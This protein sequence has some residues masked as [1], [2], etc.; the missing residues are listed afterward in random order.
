[1]PEGRVA[2]RRGELGR[3]RLA[4]LEHVLAVADRDG[5]HRGPLAVE[6]EHLLGRLRAQADG[7]DVPD[8]QHAAGRSRDHGPRDRLDALVRTGGLERE[9]PRA[10]VD[11]AARDARVA[12][13]QRL[14][15]LPDRHA[16]SRE[17]PEV[18][19]DARLAVRDAVIVDLLH[20]VHPL[21]LT[22]HL[23]GDAST[24]GHAASGAISAICRNIDVGRVDLLDLERPDLGRQV[25]PRRLDLAHELVV[26]LVG[27]DPW[28]ELD[29][30]ERDAVEH[31][32]FARA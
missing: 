29:D 8:R 18:E 6:P 31:A 13:A 3:D 14:D 30:Q 23:L 7:R 9:A 1:M 27:V 32:G 4:D 12:T 16:G 20:A 10:E 24:C 25:H 2:R 19:I 11:V 17:P 22:D 28:L 26:L 15:H 21:D 5:D